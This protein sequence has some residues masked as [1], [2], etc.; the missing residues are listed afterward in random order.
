LLSATLTKLVWECALKVSLPIAV[1]AQVLKA[2]GG[3]RAARRPAWLELLRLASGNHALAWADQAVVSATSFLTLIMI[4]RWTDVN[5]LGAYAI[6]ASVLALLLATQDSLIT[7][8]YAIQLYR[9]LGTPAEHAFSSLLLNFLLS[10]MGILVLGAA[11]LALSASGAHRQAAEITWAL[12]GTIPFV[13]L[14]E[15]ARRFAFA[16]FKVFQ[17]LVVDVGVAAL[18]VVLL[19][20]LGWTGRLSAV[21][22]FA[23]VGVSCA[24]ATIGWLYFA[25]SEFAFRFGHFQTTL[26]QS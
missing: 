4:A 23:A 11:A 18:N 21:T 16:H 15:F 6:G 19:G 9:P 8:P 14:R 2:E 1:T 22:A 17:A 10:A 26:K 25:R 7:R 12:A 3:E 13:L 20:W 5:Q 24:I